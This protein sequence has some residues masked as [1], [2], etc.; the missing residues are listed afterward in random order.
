MADGIT[1]KVNGVLVTNNYQND[2]KLDP[3]AP[4][5]TFYKNSDGDIVQHGKEPE[6]TTVGA[7]KIDKI[8]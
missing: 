7:A 8:K 5:Q 4:A 6:S 3:R 2:Q 1:I